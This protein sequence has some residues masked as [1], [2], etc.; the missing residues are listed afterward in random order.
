MAERAL[1]TAFVNIVPGTKDLEL[2]M[3]KGLPD[4]ADKGG[5]ES[6][7]RFGSGMLAGVK[8]LMGPIAAAFSIY[9]VVDFTKDMF[10]AAEEGQRV[11]ATLGNIT[12]SMGLFGSA[13][14]D[15]TNRLKDFAT[16][17]MKLTG[18][19]DDVI[20]GAQAKL[21]TFS[22][23]GKSAGE[24]GGQ[25]DT[26]TKLAM[27]LSAAG[28]GSV[29]SAAVMLGKALQDP[30]AGVTALKRVGVTLTEAQKEQIQAFMD[31]GDA[32]SA[33][34]VILQEVSRQVG[35]TA[36][37]SAT[38]ADKMKARWDDAV[39][40]IG[41]ALLPVLEGV[42]GFIADNILPAVEGIG[43]GLSGAF[44]W[45]QENAGW[46]VPVIAGI[47]AVILG[48]ATNI[49]ILNLTAAIAA[50]GGL[51][52]II[53]ATWAWTAALLANP[54]TW[55]ILGIGLLIAAIVALAMNWDAVTKWVSDV[56]SGF[57][58]WLSDSFNAI[59]KWWND[60]WSGVSRFVSDVWNGIVS[61]VSGVVSGFLG[62]FRE[63]WMLILGFITGPMGLAVAF[64]T[65]NWDGIVSFLRG[66]LDKIGGFFET[67]FQGIGDTVRGTFEGIVGFIKGAIN[68]VID[69]VNGAIDGI[70]S[71]GDAIR[72]A[73][74]G[75]VDINVGHVPH[76]A[77]GG[78]VD[79]PTTA[80]I[81][82]AGPEV[83]T[84]L[85]DFERMMGLDG[86]AKSGNTVNYYAAPNQSIDAEQ[87]LFTALKRAKVMGAW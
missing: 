56:W 81:G 15:V 65:K 51:P 39:Q 27:D 16:E 73:T 57:T 64:I 19:D 71:V 2:W 26:A 6:G 17:Q 32:A 42:V 31:A 69:I 43:T 61:W 9:A 72:N 21:M 37:A 54:V 60:L 78:Y 55:I 3:K 7:N 77:K 68:S 4:E 28:F 86:N 62:W 48:V 5:K 66:A 74:G 23:V 34:N 79:Q 87:A 46:L 13:A 36:A 38:A 22:E 12:K 49:G 53:A 44:Q 11:D 82:E 75:A 76:L 14:G 33:Q 25:F 20:K 41:T 47:G 30:I 83:V 85:K 59:G 29:D 18:I 40:G 67:V 8:S 58:S 10:N 50:A 1:A 52:A 35:G 63:N 70:N 80:L 24:M 84:P 45:L